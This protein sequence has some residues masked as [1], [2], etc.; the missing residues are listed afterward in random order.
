MLLV[1]KRTTQSD[2]VDILGCFF[3]LVDM[4]GCIFALTPWSCSFAQRALRQL[5]DH[6]GVWMGM[7]VWVSGWGEMDGYDVHCACRGGGGS[8]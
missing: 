6:G 7:C 4:R 3:A 8:L 2:I 5:P 1:R